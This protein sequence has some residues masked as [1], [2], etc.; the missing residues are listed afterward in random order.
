[1]LALL[2]FVAILKRFP[3]R[4]L[5]SGTAI[6]WIVA[7]F[8]VS[9]AHAVILLNDGRPTANTAEPTG[10]L[11]GSGWQ[12]QGNFGG[13]LGTPIAPRF[14]ITAKHVGGSAAIDYEGATHQVVRYYPDAFADLTICEVEGVG[15]SSFA[16]LYSGSGESGQPLVVIGRGTQ[17]GSDVIKDG[18]LRGWFWGGGDGLRRWGE[19][20]VSSIVNGGPI[21]QYLYATLDQNGLANESH[22]S[23]G[24]SGGAVFIRESGA[25]KLAGI[26][27]AVDG[28]LYSDA[29][30]NGGFTAAV[31]DTRGYYYKSG[32]QFVQI[33]GTT[34]QPT[35]F[36]ATRISSKRSWL[37]SVIDPAGDL[38]GNGRS[39]L[40]DYAL[41]L[42][43]A[44]PSGPGATTV[45]QADGFLSIVYRRMTRAGSPQYEVQQWDGLGVWQT[46]TPAET[47]QP[48]EG[49]VQIVTARVP[50]SG[51]AMFLRV[52]ITEP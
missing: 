27:Y 46:V 21:N 12:Y 11:A 15:F 5:I 42:N 17:R 23:S 52:R 28:P 49:G 14:F 1:M 37:Y 50:M 34:P 43:T 30:G 26:N 7:C 47:I 22:L 4:T 29:A 18:S 44:A 19:N 40:L 3:P 35:G 9:G 10:D 51:D 2:A 32:N 39:N 45:A 31:F 48:L 33:T 24:D 13:F 38:D 41:E 8:A 16:P 20:V 25:W 36:Y 6:L